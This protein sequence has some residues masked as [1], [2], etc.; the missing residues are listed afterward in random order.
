M[1]ILILLGGGMMS[2]LVLENITGKREYDLFKKIAIVLSAM[3]FN[4]SVTYIVSHLLNKPIFVM[5]PT[6]S[7]L[8]IGAIFCIVY[9]LISIITGFIM[10]FVSRRIEIRTLVEINK[11]DEDRINETEKK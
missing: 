8:E 5:S 10:S 7:I 3:L 2:Y 11:N 9:I 4:V 1:N 6:G